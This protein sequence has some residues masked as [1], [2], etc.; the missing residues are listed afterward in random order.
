M[1]PVKA[2]CE[3]NNGYQKFPP[4]QVAFVSGDQARRIVARGGNVVDQAGSPL[5][6]VEQVRMLRMTEEHLAWCRDVERQSEL[7]TAIEEVN[8]ATA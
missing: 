6:L 4:G 7:M 5:P 3:I 1:I 2:T 8:N